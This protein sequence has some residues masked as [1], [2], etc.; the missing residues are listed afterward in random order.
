M[1]NSFPTRAWA[2][3][4]EKGWKITFFRVKTH[5]FLSEPTTRL[6][7]YFKRHGFRATVVRFGLLVRRFLSFPR[8]VLFYLD[9]E[10]WSPSR[11]AGDLAASLSVEKK[12]SQEE[13]VP[14][15]LQ[16][17]L[18][19]W[20]PELT[21]RNLCERFAR[22]AIIWLA[23]WDGRLAGYGWTLV[24]STVEPYYFPFGGND[25]HLF[26]FLVFPEFRGR[27]VN[28]ALV[29]HI[30]NQM[31]ADHRTRAY[32]EV[33]EWNQPQLN[34]LSKTGFRLSGAAR[35]ATVFGRTI[36]EWGSAEI[37]LAAVM[38]RV[39]GKS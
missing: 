28:P 10:D 7:Q 25:V 12:T 27:G 38:V 34:S 37:Q 11:C 14:G 36:V 33:A 8:M 5:M 2:R 32:I 21:Q 19:F 16:V 29:A 18:S 23:R 17:M 3:K 15:D 4:Q 31:S 39:S 26:D 22:G 35:K 1:S 30:L 9:L 24:G 20:N 6:V 13:I